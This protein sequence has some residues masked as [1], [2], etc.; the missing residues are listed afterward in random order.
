M[1]KAVLLLLAILSTLLSGCSNEENS[2]GIIGGADWPTAL[3]IATSIIKPIM[4]I[5]IVTAVI[6]GIILYIKKR[7]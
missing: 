2:I 6:L 5:I 1:K 3:L 7:K 4:V